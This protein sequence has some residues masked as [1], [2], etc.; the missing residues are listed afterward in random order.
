MLTKQELSVIMQLISKA[1]IKGADAITVAVLLQK[2]DKILKEEPK[3]EE[4]PKEK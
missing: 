1:D 2:I 4:K 3:K